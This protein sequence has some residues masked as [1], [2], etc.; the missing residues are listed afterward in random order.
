MSMSCVV[1]GAV[2][3]ITTDSATGPVLVPRVLILDDAAET[4][5]E[6]ARSFQERGLGTLLSVPNDTAVAI[7]ETGHIEVVILEIESP[8]RLGLE[9][10]R[11]LKAASPETEVIVTSA[12]MTIAEIVA[13]HRQGAFDVVQRPF[14]PCELGPA[15][16]RAVEKRKR[17]RE[18]LTI[19]REG[20]RLMA[21]RE[22]ERLPALAVDFVKRAMRADVVSLMLRS[23]TGGLHVAASRGIP[24]ELLTHHGTELSRRLAERVAEKRAPV[25]VEDALFLDKLL[26]ESVPFGRVRSSIVHPLIAGGEAIG[27][28]VIARSTAEQV[29]CDGDLERAGL[30]ANQ[31]AQAFE[32]LAQWQRT[33]MSDRLAIISHF[34]ASVAH[35]INNPLT[36]VVGQN[37]MALESVQL[38]LRR[39]RS[40]TAAGL[41]GL[42]ALEEVQ[43]NLEAALSAAKSVQTVVTDLRAAVHR[44]TSQEAQ[45]DL[46]EALRAAIR[47]A[48][49]EVRR[50]TV[51]VNAVDDELLVTADSGL[52]CQVFL[53]VI[54]NANQ[55]LRGEPTVTPEITI[56]A[57]SDPHEIRIDVHHCGKGGGDED[58]RLALEPFFTRTGR[59]VSPG[60][61]ISIVNDILSSLGGRL[62]VSR[63]ASG[64]IV[65]VHLPA[66]PEASTRRATAA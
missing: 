5:T 13:A 37:A 1:H 4:W 22:R 33:G 14:Q 42:Y 43:Q 28:L 26:E 34:A 11:R 62:E 30:V 35:E 55:A 53:S 19:L 41:E 52:L 3:E 44:E 8:A 15:L 6:I 32:S 29:Y 9:L 50:Q 25:I 57:S 23:R 38:L 10:M 47:L 49:A 7:V 20:Q 63:D 59:E 16:L 24:A 27:V 61:G 39:M 45:T 21:L 12:D 58:A 64:T 51:I 60:L 66:S 2:P 56:S 36:A 40:G 46:R 18:A 17:A 31:I 48:T 54:L 65:S